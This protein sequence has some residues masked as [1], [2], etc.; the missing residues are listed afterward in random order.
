MTLSC[1]KTLHSIG[2]YLAGYSMDSSTNS[3]IAQDLI[4]V[5]LLFLQN[6]Q[7]ILDPP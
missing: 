6:T 5:S 2:A 4:S 7:V 1:C 3:A